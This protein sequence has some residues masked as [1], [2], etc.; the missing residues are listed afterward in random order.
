M[1][2]CH[3]R[4]YWDLIF[5]VHYCTSDGCLFLLLS[6]DMN[7]CGATTFHYDVCTTPEI[8][9]TP[10]RAWKQAPQKYKFNSLFAKVGSSPPA[11]PRPSE[12]SALSDHLLLRHPL[13]LLSIHPPTFPH[14][15][16]HNRPAHSDFLSDMHRL[17]YEIILNALEA[18]I[19]SRRALIYVVL[20]HPNYP[21]LLPAPTLD[22]RYAERTAKYPFNLLIFLPFLL[23][24]YFIYTYHFRISLWCT[25]LTVSHRSARS[26]TGAKRI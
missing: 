5:G 1:L 22:R 3:R 24:L 9:I 10:S 4:T 15:C 21:N 17:W 13:G 11:T 12:R 20:R 14:L 2:S 19:S 8:L 6:V 23:S 16:F 7:V 18:D 26:A 25:K